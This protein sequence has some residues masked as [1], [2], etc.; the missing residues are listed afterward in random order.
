MEHIIEF[1]MEM[2]FSSSNDK[3]QRMPNGIEYK[4][5]FT[6]RSPKSQIYGYLFFTVVCIAVV[7]L[8]FLL[9][10]DVI[11]WIFIIPSVFM[12]ILVCFIAANAYVDEEKIVF[13][14]CIFTWN[15]TVK[16]ADVTHS[17]QIEYT[18]SSTVVLALYNKRK[19]LFEVCTPT[20]NMWYMIKMAERK[21]IPIIKETDTTLRE[22]YRPKGE[23]E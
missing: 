22:L 15:K 5:E 4:E 12:P 16:W 19:F 17:K 11:A 14:R 21:G 10:N 2:L 6:L 23:K 3:P 18:D 13:R 20:D 8:G 7:A 9:N 1:L